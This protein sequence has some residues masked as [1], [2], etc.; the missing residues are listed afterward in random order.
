MGARLSTGADSKQDYATPWA[1]LRAIE[2]KRLPGMGARSEYQPPWC[3]TSVKAVGERITQR[4]VELGMTY[5]QFANSCR[6]GVASVRAWESGKVLPCSEA[7]RVARV[8]GRSVE[9][10]VTGELDPPFGPSRSSHGKA[11]GSAMGELHF[12]PIAFDLAASAHNTKHEHHFT[13]ADDALSKPWS[14]IGDAS[15]RAPLLW[16]NPPFS[17]IAPW[18]KKCSQEVA[19]GSHV[20][21]LVPAAVGSN[22]FADFVFPFADVIALNGRI[23]FMPDKPS[24]G[25]PK[26]CMLCDYDPIR[27]GGDFSVWDWRASVATRA[28][29]SI[30]TVAGEE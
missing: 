25:Y 26:D 16:L 18:A 1:L 17:D 15:E 10:L 4:R 7:V 24:W 23:P 30:L 27:E 14:D 19:Q 21:M 20:L 12:G 5:T 2:T 13:E 28:A 29:R 11:A 9:W 22:W 6:V 8:C 3:D